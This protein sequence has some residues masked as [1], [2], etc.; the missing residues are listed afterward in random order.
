MQR[1]V[2]LINGAD[3]SPWEAGPQYRAGWNHPNYERRPPTPKFLFRSP[4]RLQ[5]QIRSNSLLQV[6]G[7]AVSAERHDIDPSFCTC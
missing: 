6:A 4:L 7:M 2:P 5:P 3:R 1:F